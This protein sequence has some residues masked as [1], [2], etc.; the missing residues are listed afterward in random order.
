MSGP[1]DTLG[2][3]VGF[4]RRSMRLLGIFAPWRLQAY[5]YT[6][7]AV[8]ALVLI[9]MYRYG[10]WLIDKTGAPL[11]DC[12][13]TYW[14]VGGTAALHGQAASLYDPAQLTALLKSLVGPHHAND[15]FPYQ[16]WPYP[17]VF[18]LILVPLGLLPYLAAFLIWEALALAACSLVVYWIVHQ[19]AAFA[20]MLASPFGALDFRWAQTGFLRA[21]LLGAALLVLGTRPVLA[22]VLIGCLV[23]KPQFGILIP[24]AL[25]AGKRWRA[26]AAA[27]MTILFLVG[28]SIVA[29]G[30]APW[31]AFARGL[32]AQAND[33]LGQGKASWGTVQTIYGLIRAFG[34]GAALAWIGQGCLTAAVAV[35]LWLIWRSSARYPLKAAFLSAASLVATPYAWSHDLTMLAIPIAFL[36]KDQIDRGLL[37]GEQMTLLAL[38]G[39]AFAILCHGGDLPL[40][41]VITTM[42][43]GLILRRVL[44][45]RTQPGPRLVRAAMSGSS[46]AADGCKSY[47]DDCSAGAIGG[48]F[49][50]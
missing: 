33:I 12:D 11:P 10:V 28:L 19:S 3:E 29:F 7:A 37:R 39:L 40:G 24:L 50:L 4:E 20:L 47:A 26:F 43:I 2:V 41:P 8:Y 15:L 5:G 36:V 49:A 31:E 13:F 18:L 27:A 32:F 44:R 23:F 48:H 46:P 25:I 38:F 21:S 30:I 22:G 9:G 34:G 1:V 16:N 45:D 6:L 35:L 17:P 14:W 42:L